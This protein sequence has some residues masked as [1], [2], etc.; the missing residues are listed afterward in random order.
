MSEETP[1]ETPDPGQREGLIHIE[2]G[3]QPFQSEARCP[4]CDFS[5]VRVS[6]HGCLILNTGDGQ[7]PCGSWYRSGI[8]TD[9]VGEHLC[10]RCARCGYGWPTQTADTWRPPEEPDTDLTAEE[11]P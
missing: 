6:Y 7:H 2:F 4:K 3:L 5:G 1:E 9:P 11:S 8:L 10:M